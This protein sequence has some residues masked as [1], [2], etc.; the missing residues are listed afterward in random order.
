GD[1]VYLRVPAQRAGH[2]AMTTAPGNGPAWTY[3]DAFRADEGFALD[4]DAR[5]PLGRCRELFHLPVR[6]DGRPLVYLCSHSLGLQPRA[7]RPLLEQELDNWARL[8]VEA[9]F[10][11]ETPWYTYEQQL[12]GPTARLVG[13]LPHEVVLM[14]GLTVD[15]HLMLETFYRP[16]AG[17]AC[18]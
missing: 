2:H 11:S 10:K 9:H 7:V 16:R 18:I 14:N 12:R 5:D 6:P 8:G 4:L 3:P 1:G 13:A 15:L 17:R